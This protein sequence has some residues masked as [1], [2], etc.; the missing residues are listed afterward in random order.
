MTK[1]QFQVVAAALSISGFLSQ[2]AYAQEDSHFTFD[3][4]GGFTQRPGNTARHVDT[5]WNV[6]AGVGYNFNYHLGAIL[7]FDSNTNGINGPTLTNLGYP[8]GRVNVWDFS[9]DPIVHLLPAGHTDLYVTG[10]GGVYHY[11]QEFT[12]PA[13][14]TVTA[15]DPFFGFYQAGIPINQV[16]NSYS[17][18]RPGFNVGAGVAVGTKWRAKIFA[19]AKWHR[20]LF[21]N[22]HYDMIP[23]SFGVRF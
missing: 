13:I 15:F 2:T 6:G 14:A 7:H 18:V 10:G 20:V 5:G 21:P 4:H 19:E 1:L 3:F 23:V 12:Q 11:R 8:D 16:L 22:S 9:I 17:V